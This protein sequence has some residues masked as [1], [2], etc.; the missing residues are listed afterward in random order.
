MTE[1]DISMQIEVRE[2]KDTVGR[3]RG[4]GKKNKNENTKKKDGEE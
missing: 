3:R 4:N 2:S 1:V